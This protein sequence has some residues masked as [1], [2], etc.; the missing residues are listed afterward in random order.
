MNTQQLIA[1]HE[2]AK[3]KV[4]EI[5]RL[6]KMRDSL[7]FDAKGFAGQNFPDKKEEWLRGSK[8]Y[9]ERINEA[10]VDYRKFRNNMD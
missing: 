10:M 3:K 5:A 2:K 9:Q 4:E 8:R 7:N 1:D 6:E